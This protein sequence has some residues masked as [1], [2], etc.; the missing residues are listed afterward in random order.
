[1]QHLIICC[2]NSHFLSDKACPEPVEGNVRATQFYALQTV[3]SYANPEELNRWLNKESPS[4]SQTHIATE[5]EDLA[6]D[7][8]RALKEART[9]RKQPCRA[10]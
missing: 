9:T 3:S 1:M 7:L 10:A 6:A 4:H 8:K 2:C 5:N